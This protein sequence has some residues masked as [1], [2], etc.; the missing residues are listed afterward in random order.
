[1]GAKQS[2]K[3]SHGQ[4][5]ESKAQPLTGAVVV[6]VLPTFLMDLLMACSKSRCILAVQVAHLARKVNAPHTM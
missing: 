6:E 3:A 4:A 1:M 5:K 2:I